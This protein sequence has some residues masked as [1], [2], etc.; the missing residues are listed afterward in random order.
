MKRKS[1]RDSYG[2]KCTSSFSWSRT[3][4]LRFPRFPLFAKETGIEEVVLTNIC[5]TINVWQEKQRVFVWESG[6]E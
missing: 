6:E 1:A 2:P 3:I 4:S 5:H